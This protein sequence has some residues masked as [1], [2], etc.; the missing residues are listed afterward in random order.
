MLSMACKLGYVC[1][2]A[3]A[4]G[5]FCLHTETYVCA[6]LFLITVVLSL[7]LSMFNG[8]VDIMICRRT[9]LVDGTVRGVVRL[10]VCFAL[11]LLAFF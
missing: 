2:G 9:P 11:P 4:E 10:E 5:C 6:F 1:R 8:D 7:I 3:R